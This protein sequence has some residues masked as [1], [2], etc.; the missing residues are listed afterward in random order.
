[1]TENNKKEEK[2]IEG[3]D[4]DGIQELDNP[5]PGWWLATF[6]I[7]IV[8][9]VLY[10]AYYVLGE[11]PS[12]RDELHKAEVVQEQKINAN[13]PKEGSMDE[14][15]LASFEKD[16]AHLQ[17]GKADF[18]GKCVACHGP[19]GQGIIGPNLTDNFWIHGKGTLGDIAK[20]V[21]EGVNDKGMPPW[22]P[23]L[24]P[25]E[26]VEVVVYVHSLRGSN[27]PNPKAPQGEKVD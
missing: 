26:L 23:V 9:A 1:M 2:L 14:A 11:G 4:Y 12:L 10:F 13:K 5:L 19:Q 20:V 8:F 3:H 17:A 25:D 7:S 24:K 21:S 6:Y 18:E 16:S 15:K 27:P 22:G